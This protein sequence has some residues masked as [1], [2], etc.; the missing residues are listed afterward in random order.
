MNGDNST[1]THAIDMCILPLKALTEE[2]LVNILIAYF[3]INPQRDFWEFPYFFCVFLA[4]IL[5]PEMLESPR[6]V[7][8][9][10][11]PQNSK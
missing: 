11:L 1:S 9:P 7:E 6:L 4:I 10:D 8:Q 3:I 2:I 5:E